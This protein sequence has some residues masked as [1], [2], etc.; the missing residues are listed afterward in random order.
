[1]EA[2]KLQNVIDTLSRI[3]NVPD[4]KK[5]ELITKYSTMTGNQRTADGERQATVRVTSGLGALGIKAHAERG[6][7]VVGAAERTFQQSFLP[8]DAY[9]AGIQHREQRYHQPGQQS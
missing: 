9:R 4:E 6:H 3:V 2:F 5:Q 8:R 7:N 1:M